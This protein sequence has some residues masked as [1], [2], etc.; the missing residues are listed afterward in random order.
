MVSAP[1][2]QPEEVF[3]TAAALAAVALILSLAYSFLIHRGIAQRVQSTWS[4]E[5]NDEYGLFARTLVDTETYGY[6]AHQP[7]A[8]RMPLYP[9]MLAAIYRS[10]PALLIPITQAVQAALFAATVAIVFLL[11]NRLYGFSAAVLAGVACAL[12]PNAITY[13]A[14]CQA[15]T[16]FA[17][18]LA[19]FVY[20]LSKALDEGG[21]RWV[22][23]AGLAF[24]ASLLTRPTTLL[25][26][27]LLIATVQ[28]RLR[29]I[30]AVAAIGIAMVV[31]WTV[32]N[33]ARS[34]M[35]IPLSTW[36][37]APAYHGAYFAERYF[38]D[39][40][41]GLQLDIAANVE[42][43]AAVSVR[44]GHLPSP[45]ENT[46]AREAGE[47]RIAA[48]LWRSRLAAHPF[49]T[50]LVAARSTVLTWFATYNKWSSVVSAAVHLPLLAVVL[51]S[52][53]RSRTDS[54]GE[55]VART[56]VIYFTLLH[57][58]LYPHVRYLMPAIPM[59]IVCAAPVIAAALPARLRQLFAE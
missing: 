2:R 6:Q 13:T 38:S 18:F 59:A 43:H 15:E 12:Y 25:L 52:L 28:R 45:D 5:S 17:F 39:P 9:L 10:A 57:A 44:A 11:A 7:S 31:P 34:G 21:R 8:K 50:A 42:R 33:A 16:L 46:I 47:D 23:I 58:L 36:T 41:S 37:W 3:R 32:R 14:R 40:R 29:T 24:G 20:A 26:P 1:Q 4:W 35:F 56:V 30:A 55:L 51:I 53:L 27:V 48:A 54:A 19:A 22:A 49:Q